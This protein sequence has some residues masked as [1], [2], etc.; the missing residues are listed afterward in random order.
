MAEFRDGL[1]HFIVQHSPEYINGRW[2]QPPAPGIT[3]KPT[4]ADKRRELEHIKAYI[5]GTCFDEEV[6]CDQP[7][8]CGRRTAC[9]TT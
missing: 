5:G 9:D 4:S 6:C 8:T 7:V 2:G 3:I 1:Y